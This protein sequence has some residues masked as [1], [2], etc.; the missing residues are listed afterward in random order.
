MRGMPVSVSGSAVYNCRQ[1]NKKRWMTKKTTPLLC[2]LL[3]SLP[4][5]YIFSRLLLEGT[6]LKTD[7]WNVFSGS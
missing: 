6:R 1:G 5:P 7:K 2:S 3:T 4:P